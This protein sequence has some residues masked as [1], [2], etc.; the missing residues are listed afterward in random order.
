MIEEE[1]IS[2][3]PTQEYFSL[4][5]MLGS[6]C[7]Y[8]CMYCPAELHDITSRPHSLEVMQKVWQNVHEKSKHKNLPYKICFTGG[9]VTANKN[10]LPLVQWLRNSYSE[11]SMIQL[12]TNGS[13]S[14]R[15][16]EDLCNSVEGIS[17]STHSEFIDEQ[18]FFT[19][20]E[21]VNELM[22]RPQKS[23][24]VNI[25]DEHWNQDRI[26]LYKKWLDQR[27]ISYSINSIDYAHATRATI[28]QQGSY[29]LDA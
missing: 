28:L 14:Q 8:D 6:L 29:N 18:R 10:F 20:V 16:Y 11:I 3:T 5:W 7:N 19:T 13:A 9:E 4:S 27:G 23:V 2:V 25:M 24:H 21:S 17:F 12:T 22:V 26:L 15:Y 1:I